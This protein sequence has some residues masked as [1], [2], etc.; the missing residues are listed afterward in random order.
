MRVNIGGGR[1]SA[2]VGRVSPRPQ[3]HRQSIAPLGPMLLAL[4]TVLGGTGYSYVLG[5]AVSERRA[6]PTA[7]KITW[8]TAAHWRSR[9]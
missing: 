7:T 2:Q 4:A 1:S 5:P 3:D 8:S 9:D 6:L